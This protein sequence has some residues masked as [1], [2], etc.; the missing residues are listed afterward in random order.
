[1]ERYGFQAVGRIKAGI[2][3]FHRDQNYGSVLQAYALSKTIEAMGADCRVIDYRS[4]V[5]GPAGKKNL[6]L[7]K[8]N[9]ETDVFEDFICRN[10][11]LTGQIYHSLEELRET[12]QVFDVFITG[13]GQVWNGR[14]PMDEAYFL[15]FLKD[16]HK[17]NAYAASFG[18]DA[19]TK[20]AA[21]KMS[22]WLNNFQNI[23]IREGTDMPILKRLTG[24]E[25]YCCLDPILLLEREQWEALMEPVDE[26]Y[27]LLIYGGKPDKLI[28]DAREYAAREKCKLYEIGPQTISLFRC[29]A[30][31][32]NACPTPGRLLSMFR[33]ARFVFTNSLHGVLLSLLFQ[34]NFKAE[35]VCGGMMNQRILNLLLMLDIVSRTTDAAERF[36]VDWKKVIPI[37]RKEKE[38][39]LAY[40]KKILN[41]CDTLG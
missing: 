40:L 2:L 17:K 31:R 18:D 28:R 4:L 20:S 8:G 37:L 7:G 14:Q 27:V 32:K 29:L 5:P 15:T 23:S 21:A 33:Q 6:L 38:V 19:I 3:T 30:G 9:P 16:A 24:K 35:A 34:R 36:P 1:M 39:S 12:E 26:K 11:P 13:S 22:M 25:V 41:P 10:L